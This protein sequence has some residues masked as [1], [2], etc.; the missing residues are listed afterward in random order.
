MFNYILQVPSVYGLDTTDVSLWKENV[1][2]PAI[3]II[4]SFLTKSECKHKPLPV[5]I[6][7]EASSPFFKEE[8]YVCDTCE[9]VFVGT[10][11]WNDHR[12]SQK[13]KKMLK[14]K[15]K[16]NAVKKDEIESENITKSI[17]ETQETEEQKQ[18]C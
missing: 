2:N 17:I 16:Q 15:L 6:T 11:Q 14:K 4:E 13:H 10:F 18:N 12:N 9:R 1:Q 8:T 3:E 5:K 7:S